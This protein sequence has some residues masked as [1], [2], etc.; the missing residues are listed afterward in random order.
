MKCA[1]A[2]GARL[3]NRAAAARVEQRAGDLRGPARLVRE[4]T[5]LAHPRCEFFTKM[6]ELFGRERAAEVVRH[7]EDLGPG[8]VR[9][10]VAAM[11]AARRAG[12]LE[13]GGFLFG[14]FM[15]A[16]HASVRELGG[17]LEARLGGGV[18]EQ[19]AELS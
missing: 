19:G 12:R 3:V 13:R 11:G 6:L 8:R 4:G 15:L 14:V 2:E 16:I 9:V 1:A 18:A 17:G 5:R 10:H 7:G